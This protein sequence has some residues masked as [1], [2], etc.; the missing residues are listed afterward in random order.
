VSSGSVNS[1]E[2]DRDAARRI[3][4]PSS[5]LLLL[6]LSLSLGGNAKDKEALPEKGQSHPRGLAC[7]LEFARRGRHVDA[8]PSGIQVAKLI[9][10]SRMRTRIRKDAREIR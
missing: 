6:S 2:L 9:G 7:A 4:Q 8:E 10:R 5:F 1:P 3:T